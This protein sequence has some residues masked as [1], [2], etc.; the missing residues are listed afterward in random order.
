M[1]QMRPVDE[2][3]KVEL[4]ALTAGLKRFLLEEN[5]RSLDLPGDASPLADLAKL[6]EQ[7]RASHIKLIQQNEAQTV[8]EGEFEIKRRT[9]MREIS[10]AFTDTVGKVVVDLINRGN[11][12]TQA[13]EDAVKSVDEMVKRTDSIRLA[14]QKVIDQA[15]SSSETVRVAASRA[16]AA[17]DI[18][19][20]VQ[21]AAKEIVDIVQLIDSISFQT[22]LLALNA[23][24]EAARAGEFGRG[25]SV[26]AQEVKTLANNTSEA[27]QKIKETAEGMQGAA[28]SMTEAVRAIKEAN[29][30]VSSTTA[31]TID[32][33]NEQVTAT[34]EITER[35]KTSGD[36]MSQAERRIRAIQDEA[37]RLSEKTEHFVKYVSA[38]PGVTSDAITFGQSAPFTGPIASWGVGSRAGIEIAF[39]EVIDQGGIHGRRPI[40]EAVDDKYD[41]DLALEN[42]RGLVRGGNIFG[43]MGAVGT[44]TSKLSERIARGGKVPF[45][46]P[47]TGTGFLRT[48]ERSHVVN[49]RASYGQEA[50]ALVDYFSS[51]VDISE[52]AL[53]YQADAYGLAVADALKK[54]LSG[55]NGAI[56]T[57]APYERATG[58]VSEAIEIIIEA[59]P[60]LI[61]M[62][63]TAAPTAKFVAG[64][65]N[66]GL[67]S[68]MATISF[69]GAADFAKQVGHN[70][71]GVVVSQVVPVPY[72]KGSVLTAQY[73]AA[74][75]KY[76]PKLAPDFPMLEGYILGRFVCEVLNRVGPDVTREAFLATIFQGKSAFEIGNFRLNFAPGKNQGSN[77]VYL[78]HLSKDGTYNP[79]NQS[80]RH[81]S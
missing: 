35:A 15:Q 16:D 30:R 41:P 64:I 57:L 76:A 40:L 43:L 46:G 21:S 2:N 47:I 42:V 28:N 65:R 25:F 39:A 59:Q 17:I 51:I 5:N 66:A 9:Q 31:D 48:A 14:I 18:M 69:V 67:S 81:A 29:Q 77:E 50:K 12:G 44:P 78:T 70:G 22:S 7:L 20:D 73:N 53:F 54:P 49:I 26:V 3:L 60:K 75:E 45:I 13:T 52:C 61:F 62:A 34:Q 6:V 4:D 63:G 79:L 23:S 80:L 24:I 68:A 36:Q 8:G 27:A 11:E 74:R 71:D 1:A 33:I 38:E 19:S 58:D 37:G 10:S 32:A 55:H 56:S 72:D